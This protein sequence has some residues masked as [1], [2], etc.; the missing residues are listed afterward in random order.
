MKIKFSIFVLLAMVFLAG[1]AAAQVQFPVAELG[2]CK[3]QADCKVYCDKP[4]NSDACMTFAKENN[5]MS[6]QEITVAKKFID[7][8]INGPGGCNSKDSCEEY[9]NDISRIDECIA[10]AESNNLMPSSELQDAKRVQAAIKQGI[11]P[12]AC[13]SKKACD[14]YCESSDHM[15][16]CM[17]FAME[18]GLMSDKEKG[19]AQK[20]LQ[21]VKNGIKPPPCKGKDACDA[22]CSKPE[23]MEICMTFAMEAGLMSEEEKADAQKMLLAIKQGVNPPPCKGKEECD[24]YCQEDAHIEECINFSVAAGMMDSKDAEMAKKTRGR[25][26]GGCKNKEECEAFCNN[27]ENQETCFNFQKENGLLTDEQNKNASEM[28]NVLQT[29]PQEVI[30]CLT[31]LLGADTIQKLKNGVALD[32]R[33]KQAQMDECFSKGGGGRSVPCTNPEECKSYCDSH[34]DECNEPGL[35]GPP[36]EEFQ[37]SGP[38][39]GP[40]PGGC[41][42]EAECEAY[43][44]VHPQECGAPPPGIMETECKDCPPPNINPPQDE[45][46]QQPPILQQPPE[47]QPPPVSKIINIDLLVG[48]LIDAAF[49]SIFMLR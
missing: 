19:D 2:N 43:C 28:Q 17:T 35:E 39:M 41:Q 6:D 1:Q 36:K 40:G 14:I 46:P 9:C 44:Q 12:P 47:N 10:F 20:M 11:K 22:Y 15:E 32:L 34:P 4:E 38:E 21:A 27:P 45:N 37:K 48:S 33:G 30:D 49:R 24:A 8:E 25:G 13:G 31:T 23:N 16:E 42:S 26:P 3:D 7:G 5:L 29:A 18:A